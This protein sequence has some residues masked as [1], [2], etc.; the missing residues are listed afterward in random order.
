[1][2]E[3]NNGYL[4]EVSWEVCNKVGGIYTVITSKVREAIRAYGDNYFLLGPDIKTNPDFEET[5]EDC[6][7]EIREH[8]AIREIPCRFGRWKIP[9]EPKVILVSSGEKYNKDQLLYS[10]WED[11]GV[12][13][14]AGGWDYVEPVMF[15]YA[16]GEVIETIYNL[17]ARPEDIPTVAQFHEWMTGAGLLYLKKRAPEIGAVFTTHATILGRSLAGAGM[18][19]YSMMENISPQR[20]ATT[21]NITAKYSMELVAAREADCFTTV[22][23]ITASEAKNFLG[24]SPTIITP[25]GLDMDR[26]PDLTV[27]RTPAVKSRERLLAAASKFLRKDL[28][29]NTKIVNISGR[30][31]FHNKGIDIF[32]NVLGRLDKEMT[33]NESLLAYLFVLG[34]HTDLIPSLQ[35]GY[36]RAET[37]NPP[38]ATHRLHYEAS[39]PILETCGRVGLRNTP[40]NKVNVIF[41]PTYLT[42]HNGLINM[43]YYEALSGCDLG[44]FPSYYEP[45]GYTPLESAAYA[46]PTITTDQ[47]GFGL[48]VLS[49]IGENRGVI[50]LPRKGQAMNVIEDNL[51]SI[52][53]DFLTWSDT[54]LLERRKIARD[55]ALRT[56]WEDFFGAY[57]EAYDK[58]LA[59]ARVRSEKL[60]SIGYRE[61]KPPITLVVSTQPHFRMFTAIANLPPKIERLR[62]MAYNL[63]WTWNPEALD[64]FA[65]LAPRTWTEMKNN[66]VRMLETVSRERLL[67]MSE[68]PSYMHLY[69][70]IMQKFDEYMSEKSPCAKVEISEEI[71]S[72]SPIAYFSTEYGLHGSIPIY[73]G[74]LGILSGDHLKTASDLNI[75]LVGVG[76]LYKSGYFKQI[77]DNNGIQ[78]AEYPE[79]DFSNMPVQI[80]QDDR[81][82]EVQISLELPGRTLFA[83]VWEARVGRVSLYLLDTDVPRNTAQDKKIT[84]RLYYA[85][86]RTRIEQEILLGAGGVKLLKKLGIKPCVYHLNEGHSAFLL[87][88]RISALMTEEGLSFEEACEVVRGRTVFTTHTPVEAGHERFSKELMEHYFSGFVKRTGISWSQFWEL[89][90]KESGEDKP[91]FMTVLALKLT[92]MSNAVSRIHGR[93]SRRM[94][95]DV[96]KGF[97]ETDTPIRHITNGVHVMSYM[98]PRMKELLE[99]YLGVD[100][101][102]MISDPEVWARIQEI[103][104]ALL[105]RTRYEIKQRTIEF[106]SDYISRNWEKYGYTK[107]WQE[108]L[109][110]GINPA[111]LLIGFARRFAPYK[112]ADLLLSDLDR[113]ER[114]L[115]HQTRPVHII[116]AGKAHPNDE[117][118]KSLIKKVIDACKDKRFKGKMFF[119]EDYDIRVARHLVQG[120]DVW[121]NTPR[122][123]YEASG[124]S[125]IK[126][127]ANGVLNL[128]VADGWWAEGYDGTNGWTIGTV[129]K[130]RLEDTVHTDE[131]DSRSLYSLLENSVIPTF[132]DREVS[133]LPE[134]WI[135]MIKRSMQ[136][137]GPKFTS[138]RMLLQYYQEMYLPTVRRT[139]KLNEDSYKLAKE[140]ADWKLKIPIRFSSL[141][142]LDVN[143]GGLHGSTVL[144]AQPLLVEVMIDPGRLEPEEILVEMVIGKKEG[145]DF[146]DNPECVP[147]E[148]VKR[149]ADGV[150]TFSVAYV[151]QENGSYCYG[152]R[153]MPYNKNAPYRHEAGLVLWG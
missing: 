71:K 149:G 65:L 57:R 90:R 92:Q 45:W 10:M 107:M 146:A 25:N 125:G 22:S 40:G 123:H 148:I 143:I 94:W 103:P 134:K 39:D 85:D 58:A 13:S 1:M 48:F 127:A 64:L 120:V 28:P 62:E 101:G 108:E 42:G 102:T 105:W 91:F 116:F 56:N 135:S 27:D 112:R 66:P 74:G 37:G 109:L 35:S 47:A 51:Y 100:C 153:V 67:A 15:S 144:V 124:T 59:V 152:I 34:S 2:T 99:T 79:N 77:I 29:A 63:W 31:E 141:K 147:L 119:I 12:D 113:L 4:F 69:A 145:D 60:V 20:E 106:L 54:E 84:E 140:L 72:S 55:V 114:I 9:G 93:V 89:G 24:H 82:N 138:E 81:G 133:G 75:P 129:E 122:R 68:N 137:L 151:V 38:I 14:I 70:E 139:G 128:S 96:W 44:V 61:A 121:L 111:A 11:Y 3:N 46:V 88:E 26:I 87:F 33:E 86:Q 73:S 16:C 43:T 95:R 115:N 17:L 150:L 132:Y 110:S 97:H 126:A 6:W 130:G 131:E 78:M 76:L 32:L 21:Y 49:A 104:D 52:L 117:M 18:D 118:G 7:K 30:Y 19:I 136:T 36:T 98:A 23:E 142:I 83:N 50:L 53:K 5:E 41:I 8:T 80:V